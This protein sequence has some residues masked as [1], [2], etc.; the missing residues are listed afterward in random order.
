MRVRVYSLCMCV[1]DCVCGCFSHL[2]YFI[3]FTF[4]DL[5]AEIAYFP[6]TQKAKRK[7][8]YCYYFLFVP[9][10]VIAFSLTAIAI[11]IALSSPVGSLKTRFCGKFNQLLLLIDSE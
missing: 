8:A 11:A 4:Y 3:T 7:L 5:F 6:F 10:T 2:L 9:A 1:Y